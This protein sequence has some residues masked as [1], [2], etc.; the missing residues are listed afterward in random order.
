MISSIANDGI[1]R[2]AIG[3]KE[4]F[5]MILIVALSSS[6]S[7]QLESSSKILL[8]F[9]EQMSRENIFDPVNYKLIANENIPVEIIKVGLVKGDSAVVLFFYKENYWFGFQIT[10]QNL[11]DKAG[12]F[13]NNE[14]NFAE[15]VTA[16]Q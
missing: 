15:V 5:V 10:V 11:K 4:L 3:Y 7:A 16:L 8:T 6:V 2:W 13:I 1:H 14:K 12:N 9:S